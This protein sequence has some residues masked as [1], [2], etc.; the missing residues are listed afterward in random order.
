MRSFLLDL[1][2]SCYLYMKA[3]DLYIK[4]TTLPYLTSYWFSVSFSVHSLG[5]SRYKIISTKRYFFFLL[6]FFKIFVPLLSFFSIILWTILQYK[7]KWKCSAWE[8]M[9]YSWLKWV[10]FQK[11]NWTLIYDTPYIWYLM[12]D[13]RTKSKPIQGLHGNN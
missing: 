11:N 5:F 13:N 7:V 10:E 2:H 3:I 6:A 4:V 8:Y 12:Y 9:S 1:A